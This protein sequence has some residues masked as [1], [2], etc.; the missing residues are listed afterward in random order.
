MFNTPWECFKEELEQIRQ[1]IVKYFPDIDEEIE[2][3]FEKEKK[4]FGG[5]M[6][7][8]NQMRLR[9]IKLQR[10]ER[11]LKILVIYILRKT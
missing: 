1:I 3:I 6:M 11:I 4:F 7:Q 2:P 8:N 10:E 9:K 5:G